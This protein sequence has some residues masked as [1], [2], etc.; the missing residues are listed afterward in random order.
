MGKITLYGW[1]NV[2][3]AASTCTTGSDGACSE[4]LGQA[5]QPLA[6]VTWTLPTDWARHLVLSS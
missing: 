4:E 5:K 6:R 2:T 1:L 3:G